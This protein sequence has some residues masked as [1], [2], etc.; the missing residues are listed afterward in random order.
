M[1]DESSRDTAISHHVRI[2]RASVVCGGLSLPVVVAHHTLKP[3]RMSHCSV[4]T[5]RTTPSVN[6]M[7]RM[8]VCMIVQ[9]TDGV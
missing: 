4:N 6:T 1:D 7:Q 9:R 2:V 8:P 3:G 5:S